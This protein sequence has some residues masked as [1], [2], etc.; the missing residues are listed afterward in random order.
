[1][2][3]YRILKETN[4]HDLAFEF[5]DFQFVEDREAVRQQLETNIRQSKG[6]WFL[7]LDE[8]INH[9]GE[10]GI[11]GAKRVTPDIEAEFINTIT[12]TFG[13][14]ELRNIE[15]LLE[16]NV[17]SV[18]AAYLDEFSTELQTLEV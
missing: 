4:Q 17:L 15:F 10:D 16:N 18:N 6:D 14:V 7:N 5:G 9:A 1:M 13:V 8:G 12:G 11:I 3:V 2:A